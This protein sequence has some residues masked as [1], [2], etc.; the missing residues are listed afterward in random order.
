LES[1]VEQLRQDLVKKLRNEHMEIARSSVKEEI[2][3]EKNSDG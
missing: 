1:T 3:K 2:T